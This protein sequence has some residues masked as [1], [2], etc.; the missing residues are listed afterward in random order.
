M[1]QPVN[2]TEVPAAARGAVQK[3][4]AVNLADVPLAEREALQ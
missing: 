3:S 4:R 2:V 1:S